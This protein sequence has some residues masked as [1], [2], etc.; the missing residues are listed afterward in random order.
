MEPRTIGLV[1]LVVVLLAFVLDNRDDTTVG[2]VLFEVTAPLIWI[3]LGTAV[4]GALA[5]FL[6][7]RRRRRD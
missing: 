5:G 2:F 6:I 4:M 7:G 3:L 1:A